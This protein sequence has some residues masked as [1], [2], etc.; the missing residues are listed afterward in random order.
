[1]RAD[2]FFGKSLKEKPRRMLNMERVLILTAL[3]ISFPGRW[4]VIVMS[5]L[6]LAC[7]EN[8]S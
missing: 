6:T 4:Q 2:L 8:L 7:Q 1:M 3:S 5:Y